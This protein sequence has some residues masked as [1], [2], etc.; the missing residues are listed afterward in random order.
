MALGAASRGPGCF[1]I[2]YLLGLCVCPPQRLPAT[3]SPCSSQHSAFLATDVFCKVN[4]TD[5]LAPSCVLHCLNMK[6]WGYMSTVPRS[7]AHTQS[8]YWSLLLLLPP[9]LL[10]SYRKVHLRC[11]CSEQMHSHIS[12]VIIYIRCHQSFWVEIDKKQW[13]LGILPLMSSPLF[14]GT[15]RFILAG[16]VAWCA[17]ML[18]GS[19]FREQIESQ[20]RFL[21]LCTLTSALQR[22]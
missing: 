12:K 22:L 7:L 20:I 8:Q 16:D 3:I 13:L 18:Q 9:L 19:P 15:E 4:I 17:H 5:C 14:Q 10:S 21:E 11:L 6:Q 2:P 1:R